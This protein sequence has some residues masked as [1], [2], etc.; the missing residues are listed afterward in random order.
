MRV[1]GTS[2]CAQLLENRFL[3]FISPVEYKTLSCP[4]KATAANLSSIIY[5]F[6]FIKRASLYFNRSLVELGKKKMVTLFY[7]QYKKCLI[8]NCSVID[9]EPLNRMIVLYIR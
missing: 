1:S 9:G 7:N 3:R 5:I 8:I 2:F 4:T 6:S